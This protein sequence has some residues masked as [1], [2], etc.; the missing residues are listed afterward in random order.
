MVP[1]MRTGKIQG[2]LLKLGIMLSLSTIRRII[3]AFR[4]EGK[5]KPA[6]T[7]KKFIKA[8]IN[9]LFSMDFFT[10]TTL[11][12]K[13]FYVFFIMYLKTREIMQF[14]VTDVP[15]AF[16]VRNQLTGF[17]YDR[18]DKKTYLIHDGSGE[19]I[20][21]D[22][23]G[24][25]IRNI[26]ISPESPNMNAHAERFIG[27]VRRECLNWFIL[28]SYKQL[29]RILKEYINYYNTMRPHQGIMQ[30]IPNGYTPQDGHGR[31]LKKPILSG[32][33][34]HYYREAA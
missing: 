18:E 19:F 4:K 1:F 6:L 32:L 29:D 31:I 24:L 28:F 14:K 9:K 11:F 30:D 27:S 17:M 33:W 21:Q 23:K 13:T 12:G 2:E 7:W 20:F 16:F 26:R 3:A 34:N 5:I 8:Q 15:S 22:Y 25:G 10:V